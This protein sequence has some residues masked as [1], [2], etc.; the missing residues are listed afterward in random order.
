LNLL[1]Q[2]KIR[3]YV[4]TQPNLEF[5]KGLPNEMFFQCHQRYLVNLEKV[6]VLKKDFVIIHNAEIP[7]SQKYK[8]EMEALFDAL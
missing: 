6:T 8:Q 5:K 2:Y 7:I 1:I 3:A 4:T